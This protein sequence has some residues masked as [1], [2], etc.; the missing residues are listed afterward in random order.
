MMDEVEANGRFD[1][2]SP[3]W[4]FA[5]RVYAEPG[6]SP[7]CLMLQDENGV[8]VNL[9]LF[10][11]WCG[12]TGRRLTMQHVETAAAST[13]AWTEGVVRHLRSARRAWKLFGPDEPQAW[14]GRETL[15]SV[16]LLSERIVCAM[17]YG[18]ADRFGIAREPEPLRPGAL[19]ANL[20]LV[21]NRNGVA[22]DRVEAASRVL[23]EA[24]AT[25]G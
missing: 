11:C 18:M 2:D 15:K 13:V 17:L 16:E 10:A 24:C 5:L 22:K 7:L 25:A 9:L 8:D 12:C 1:L 23:V 21:L 4:R 3:F 19:T 14:A 20:A 6:V